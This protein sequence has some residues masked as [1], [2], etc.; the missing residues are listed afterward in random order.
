[1]VG[2]NCTV[3]DVRRPG[4]LDRYGD[5][6][7]PSDASPIWEGRVPAHIRREEIHGTE[8]NRSTRL[9]RDVLYIRGAYGVPVS[10][11]TPG[12]QKS[13]STVLVDDLRGSTTVRRRFRVVKVSNRAAGTIA[14][15][16]R[17]ELDD[18]REE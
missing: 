6:S 16:V 15:S 11:I 3:V 12:D 4:A 5:V 9:E 7:D 14:D 13:G 17:L 1:M 18:E 10:E 2:E 8:S